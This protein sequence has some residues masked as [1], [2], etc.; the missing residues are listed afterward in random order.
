MINKNQGSRGS[1]YSAH[2]HTV[3]YDAARSG[4]R[5][6]HPEG[7]V[8]HAE[9]LFQRLRVGVRVKGQYSTWCVKMTGS[10][11]DPQGTGLMQVARHSAATRV[12]SN[13]WLGCSFAAPRGQ[14]RGA[15]RRL[16]PKEEDRGRRPCDF[17]TNCVQAQGRW[18]LRDPVRFAQARSAFVFVFFSK[19]G[20]TCVPLAQLST[21]GACTL[22]CKHKGVR[23]S[24][25]FFNSTK[26]SSTFFAISANAIGLRIKVELGPFSIAA[27]HHRGSP[28]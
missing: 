2:S 6:S 19:V 27:T 9:R 24:A 1:V 16:G 22:V 26:Q 23:A 20:R 4:W 10:R 18:S 28:F 7:S 13:L 14:H 3:L 15:R 8:M 17:V 5:Q 21:K 11:R 12:T 25:P